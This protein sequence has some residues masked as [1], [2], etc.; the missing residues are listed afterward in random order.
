MRCAAKKE[1]TIS[2]T[3]QQPVTETWK[4]VQLQISENG[5][6]CVTNIEDALSPAVDQLNNNIT[7][8]DDKLK[9][10]PVE[11]EKK[12]EVIQKEDKKEVSVENK[13]E[14]EQEKVEIV[15]TEPEKVIKVEEKVEPPP[16]R[17]APE[18]ESVIPAKQ[19]RL[20]KEKSE[21]PSLKNVQQLSSNH[22]LKIHSQQISRPP[23]QPVL[24]P[25]NLQYS[26]V[27]I[28]PRR[29]IPPAYKTLR[30][31]PRA[32]NP[33]L[34]PRP[35]PHGP[36]T[37]PTQ[38]QTQP[39]PAKF[40]KARNNVPR[41]LGNPASGV[42]PM[43]QVPKT[44][45]PGESIRN[46][47]DGLRTERE[48]SRIEREGP[49]NER[50]GPRNEREGPRME[51]EGPRTER[52]GPR[53]IGEGRPATPRPPQLKINQSTVP[54]LNPLRDKVK[55]DRRPPNGKKEKPQISFTPPN[56]FVPQLGSAS[57][58]PPNHWAGGPPPVYFP[59]PGLFYQQR[60]AIQGPP[61]S[62][63]PAPPPPSAATATSPDPKLAAA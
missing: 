46:E 1:S 53:M 30:D 25:P 37:T 39:K 40:F 52:E 23:P 17:E 34:P 28:V 33:Q 32:W 42:K 61:R 6:M 26:R 47:R 50:E 31:P 21:K 56:P 22:P 62:P 7:Q 20:D 36:Q 60:Y 9:E 51:R 44:P 54:I 18:I 15:E 2:E 59:P 45:P 55:S 57:L 24:P 3:T 12:E 14:K 13:V 11:P 63:R 43:Y 29:N 8:Q 48:G 49:R 35:A 10:K 5:I 16:K 27:S 38:P 41:Y 19:P 58:P 4:E